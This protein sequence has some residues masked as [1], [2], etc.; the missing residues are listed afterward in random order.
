VEG[1]GFG[2]LLLTHVSDGISAGGAEEERGGAL[3]LFR[4]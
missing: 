4:V 3:Q 2:S 1:L